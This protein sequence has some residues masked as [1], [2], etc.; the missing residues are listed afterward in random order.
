MKSLKEF[1]EFKIIELA[2]FEL[3]PYLILMVVFAF[4]VTRIVLWIVKKL[5]NRR[6]TKDTL[7][8]GQRYALYKLVKYI[9]YVMAVGIV[10]ESIGLQISFLIVGSSALFL[11]LGF[12]LQNLFN[13]FI[14]GIMLLLG[15]TIK[16]GDIVEIEGAVGKVKQIG[17]R[18]SSIETRESIIM[19]IPNSSFTRDKVINWSHNKTVT[20]FQ[21][22]V[23]VAY[24]SDLKKVT[25]VLLEIVSDEPDI[26]E[27]PKPSVR[28][29][30]FG[31]SS[32]ELSLRFW[33]SNIFRVERIKSSLRFKIDEI[34]R[35]ND[36]EIPFPQ[37]DLHLRSS[38]VPLK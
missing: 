28:F 35:E 38:D 29:D 15:S 21:I 32:L 17:F 2:N 5:F 22:D 3:T 30:N 18:T 14:S 23:G 33:S 31:D 11:G 7:G 34:F 8:E 13:D 19:I 36:I 6:K 26:L 1:L 25:E 10:M 4:V 16:V 24:G 20:R 12:G 37:R 27:D 9:I